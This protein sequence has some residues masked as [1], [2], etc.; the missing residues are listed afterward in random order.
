MKFEIPIL[1]LIF[2]RPETTQSVFD[3]I[4]KIEPQH[5]FIAG[6]GPR[7]E[8][9]VEKVQTARNIIKLINWQCKV[10]TL[11]RNTN[12][13]CK[14]AVSSAIDWFFENNELGIILEDDCLPHIDF[15]TYSRELLFKYKD[16]P[17]VMHISGYNGLDK[18]LI[19]ESYYFSKFG[20]IWGWATWRRAW[21]NYDVEM[22]SWKETKES[23]SYKNFCDS[24]IEE[25]WRIDLFDRV[26]KGLID[27]WDYQWSFAKLL[28]NGLSI[29]PANNLITNI[30]F[31]Q[32]ATHTGYKNPISNVKVEKGVSFPLVHPEKIERNKQ[33]DRKFFYGF[34]VKNKIKNR[35]NNIFGK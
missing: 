23:K 25:L 15:F 1:F 35:I 27:T 17:K 26:A 9:E 4:K 31:N 29:I 19:K 12:L 13:G 7:N 3:V 5:L 14:I 10:K 11:F 21:K 34:V 16:E 33:L 20:T 8:E 24:K 30:G 2:N 18:V 28:N 6:D 32:S 22:K